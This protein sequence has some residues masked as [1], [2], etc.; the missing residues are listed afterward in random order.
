MKINEE[1][2]QTYDAV[3]LAAEQNGTAVETILE[4]VKV[5]IGD[6]LVAVLRD[7]QAT[8]D[9]RNRLI[10]EQANQGLHQIAEIASRI[11][12]PASSGVDDVTSIRNALTA[13]HEWL[14]TQGRTMTALGIRLDDLQRQTKTPAAAGDVPAD[15]REQVQQLSVKV[16]A[17]QEIIQNAIGTLGEHAELLVTLCGKDKIG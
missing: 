9:E 10:V 2:Q 12:G 8:L 15:L 11:G 17:L 13:Q 14:E 1:L 4:L 5:G 16:G 3:R 6:D 7:V